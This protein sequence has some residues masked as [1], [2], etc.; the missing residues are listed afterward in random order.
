MYDKSFNFYYIKYVLFDR[1]VSFDE[2]MII[3]FEIYPRLY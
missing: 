1:L 2:Y 3:T